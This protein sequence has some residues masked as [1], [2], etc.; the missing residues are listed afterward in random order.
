MK[1][2]LRA[3]AR[4]VDP[5]AFEWAFDDCELFALVSCAQ[6]ILPRMI[7]LVV[8]AICEEHTPDPLPAAIESA[9]DS[10]PELVHPVISLHE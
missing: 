7:E 8:K 9:R 2:N 10:R 3:P 4:G 1:I 5:N 6:E